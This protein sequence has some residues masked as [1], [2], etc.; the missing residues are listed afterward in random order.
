MYVFEPPVFLTHADLRR[1]Y[2]RALSWVRQQIQKHY[3]PKPVQFD[4]GASYLR[5]SAKVE[6]WEEHGITTS[7]N[8]GG[9]P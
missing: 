9:T 6:A 8:G 2:S 7:L 1:R 3:F 4:N 5:H